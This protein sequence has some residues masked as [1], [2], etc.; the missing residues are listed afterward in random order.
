MAREEW[1]GRN[2]GGGMAGKGRGATDGPSGAAAPSRYASSS[3]LCG[4]AGP[5]R[6]ASSKAS[7]RAMNF[8]AGTSSA[9]AVGAMPRSSSQHAWRPIAA[10]RATHLASLGERARHDLLQRRFAARTDTGPPATAPCAPPPRRRGGGGSKA[11][12]GTSNSFSMDSVTAASRT[13]AHSRPMTAA[14]PCGRLP[15]AAA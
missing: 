1:R 15:P 13:A 10:G 5:T 9:R 12:G 4:R 3:A 2:G 6:P 8:A 11:S 7:A 14:P